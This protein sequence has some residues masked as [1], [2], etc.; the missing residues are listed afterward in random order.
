MAPRARS[1]STILSNHSVHRRAVAEKINGDL[2]S[3]SF[4]TFL[5]CVSGGGIDPVRLP[6]PVHRYGKRSRDRHMWLLRIGAI[7]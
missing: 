7:P 6:S 5:L 2:F 3:F 4:L 1:D